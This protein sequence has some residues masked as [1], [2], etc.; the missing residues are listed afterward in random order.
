MTKV[1]KGTKKISNAEWIRQ[2]L[3]ELVDKHA[4][5]YAIVANGEAFIGYDSVELEK[6][7]HKRHPGVKLTGLPIPRP[8]DFQCAL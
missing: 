2:H 7:A 8:E 6:E 3:G 4:G 1:R 5:K